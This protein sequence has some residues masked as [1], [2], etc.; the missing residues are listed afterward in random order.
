MKTVHHK[1]SEEAI[2]LYKNM[3]HDPKYVTIREVSSGIVDE[4]FF[5]MFSCYMGLRRYFIGRIRA[6]LIV[7]KDHEK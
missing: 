3:I 2:L 1:L 5:G 7:K 6:R 4:P